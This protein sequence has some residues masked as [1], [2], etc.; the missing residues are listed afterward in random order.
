MNSSDDH[1]SEVGEARRREILATVLRAARQQR[2]RRLA[3]RGAIVLVPCMLAGMLIVR[4][5]RP[6]AAPPIAAQQPRE[7][8][9]GIRVEY[10]H[11]EPGIAKRLAAPESKLV[12]E[13]LDDERLLDLLAREGHP[14]GIVR[15]AGRATLVLGGEM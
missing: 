11:D 12:V 5:N 14:A 6:A 13:Y 2:R 7:D 4:A 15:S 3:L 1:L 8:V 9:A 10:L